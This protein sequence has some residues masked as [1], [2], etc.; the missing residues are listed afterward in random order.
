M[1]RQVTISGTTYNLPSQG[2][3]PPWGKELSDLIY[4]LSS[5]VG[6]LNGTGDILNTNFTVANNQVAAANVTGL[7][8]D[9][10]T[11]RSAIISYSVFRST[12]DNEAGECGFLLITYLTDADA[13]TIS[14]YS[15]ADAGLVFSVTDSGQ[16]QYTSTSI[17]GASYAGL[18]KF[19][20]KAFTQS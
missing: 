10:G 16:V 1:A 14:R 4:A 17:S 13:W 7:T 9:V 12:A 3:N 5:V 15:N 8:F 2:E 19:N 20:A 18:M 11:I 6:T